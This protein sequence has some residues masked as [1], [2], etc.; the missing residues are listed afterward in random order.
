MLFQNLNLLRIYDRNVYDLIYD[1]SDSETADS[2]LYTFD[3]VVMEEEV[4]SS[5]IQD[6]SGNLAQVVK[7]QFRTKHD[8]FYFLYFYIS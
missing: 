5:E 8:V 2:K 7:L 4:T 6:M 1:I 3:D